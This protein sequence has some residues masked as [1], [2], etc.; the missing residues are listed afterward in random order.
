MTPARR[1]SASGAWQSP[2]E[3]GNGP[4]LTRGDNDALDALAILA[5]P[6]VFTQSHP[7]TT[8]DLINEA[9]ELGI[10]LD[11]ATLRELYRRGYVRPLVE[12]MTRTVAAPREVPPGPALG[13]PTLAAIHRSLATGRIRDL[14]RTPYRRKLRFDT[15]RLHDPPG[16]QNGLIYSRW[17]LLALADLRSILQQRKVI[18]PYERRRVI[19]PAITDWSLQR[20]ELSARWAMVLTALEPAYLPSVVPEWLHLMSAEAEQWR[21]F[22][23]TFDP[24]EAASTLGVTPPE[25][26]NYAESLLSQARRA[27][28]TGDWSQLIRRGSKDSWKTL[29]RDAR[30]AHNL[31]IA[32]EILLLF[33]EQLVEEGQTAPLPTIDGMAWHPL[34]ERISDRSGKE[35]DRLLGGFGI[36]PHPGVVFVVEGEVEELTVP[37]VFDHLGISRAP[38]LVRVLCMRG[39]A[40]HKQLPLVAAATAAPIVGQRRRD[41][42]DMIRPPTRLLIAIDR[43]QPWDTP[44]KIQQRRK[45]ILDEIRKVLAAQGAIVRDEDLEELVLVRQ[46]HAKCFEFAHFSDDELADAM[47]AIHATCGRL[48]RDSLIA[49]I[50]V[51]RL[52][53]LDVEA[54]WDAD[55]IPKPSKTD[56]AKALWPVLAAQ[57]DVAQQ[58]PNAAVPEVVKV[59]IE[60]YQLAKRA[61]IGNFVIRASEADA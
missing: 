60:G 4:T 16:W 10:D 29:T 59:V 23:K 30:A 26:K 9:K 39:A 7:L 5:R 15:R 51:V 14:A 17:Q 46:W 12:L 41:S 42:Y 1:S 20:V 18:G 28:P 48:D 13:S 31:R 34:H 33:Y 19:L 35:L 8:S 40:K 38:D 3:Q 25:V 55:W 56:L 53:G 36:S 47:M 61:T 6:W 50:A 45:L 43:D 57:I 27:D 21:E 49:K 58:D 37:R 11:P 54:V 32:A 52:R 44:E 2:E 22:R 24:V